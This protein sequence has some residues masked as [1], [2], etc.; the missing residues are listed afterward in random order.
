M[1][2]EKKT[3]TVTN[4]QIIQPY[5]FISGIAF[6]LLTEI[7]KQGDPER[8]RRASQKMREAQKCRFRTSSS[9]VIGIKDLPVYA[10]CCTF[11]FNSCAT[12]FGVSPLR[13]LIKLLNQLTTA[14]NTVKGELSAKRLTRG[15]A[16]TLRRRFARLQC[17]IKSRMERS[18]GGH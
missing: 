2:K 11:I 4:N 13:G 15:A 1:E 12:V 5:I 8:N 3:I 10:V 14:A 7:Y 18:G 6:Y 9:A 17:E 16:E